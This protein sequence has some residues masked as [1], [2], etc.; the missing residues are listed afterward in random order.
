MRQYEIRLEGWVTDVVFVTAANRVDALEQ[1]TREFINRK[2][3]ENCRA[4][5]IE[6]EE[7]NDD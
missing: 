5:V 2:G 4:D 7:Y 3:V 1:A 6:I